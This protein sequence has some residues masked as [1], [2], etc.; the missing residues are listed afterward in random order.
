MVVESETDALQMDTSIP[1]VPIASIATAA[2]A[3]EVGDAVQHSFASKNFVDTEVQ[4][5]VQELD[6]TLNTD[7]SDSGVADMNILPG[8]LPSTVTLSFF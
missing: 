7:K 4:P 8:D 5:E 2:L 6:E 3:S 1:V